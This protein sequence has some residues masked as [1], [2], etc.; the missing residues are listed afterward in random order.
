MEW[1]AWYPRLVQ[2]HWR[3]KILRVIVEIR[4]WHSNR[5]YVPTMNEGAK[6]ENQDDAEGLKAAFLKVG[7]RGEER[8]E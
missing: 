3:R 7:P 4:V 1:Y 5:R 6:C 2:A 8:W